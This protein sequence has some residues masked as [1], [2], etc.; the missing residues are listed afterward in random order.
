MILKDWWV[1]NHLWSRIT[2]D[3][4]RNNRAFEKSCPDFSFFWWFVRRKLLGSAVDCPHPVKGL[5][6]KA[7]CTSSILIHFISFEDSVSETLKELSDPATERQKG[8]LL[9]RFQTGRKNTGWQDSARADC[10]ARPRGGARGAEPNKGRTQEEEPLVP[11]QVSSQN[12]GAG[13][14]EEAG[15]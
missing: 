7:V 8:W 15:P 12:Y 2:I 1:K 10:L 13:S 9:T 11:S 14:G 4:S 6:V 3:P 5:R